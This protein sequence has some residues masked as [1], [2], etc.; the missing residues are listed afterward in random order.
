[1]LEIH[2]LF[3][4]RHQDVAG[5]CSRHFLSLLQ[6]NEDGVVSKYLIDFQ[7]NIPKIDVFKLYIAIFGL[8]MMIKVIRWGSLSR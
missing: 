2:A 5:S 8:E 3:F 7:N 4:G 6:S 1:D